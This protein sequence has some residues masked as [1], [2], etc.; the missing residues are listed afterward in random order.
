MAVVY[1]AKVLEDKK[2]VTRTLTR[3]ESKCEL[4]L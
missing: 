2:D 4:C 1:Q 3:F